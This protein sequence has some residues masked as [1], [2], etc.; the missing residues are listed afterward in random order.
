MRGGGPGPQLQVVA[1]S[2]WV[3]KLIIIN[4]GIWFFLQV[5]LEGLILGQGTLTSFFGFTPRLVIEYFFIWQPFSYMFLHSENVFHILFNMISLWF[6]GSE[7]EY[8]WGSRA[9]LKYYFICGVGA[10]LIYIL[11]VVIYGLIQGQEPVVYGIPVIGASGAV[12][13][14]LLAYGILFGDRLIYFFGVF[15]MQ[16]KVFVMLIGGVE[17]LTLMSAGLGGSRVANL[18]HIGGLLTGFLYLVVWTRWQQGRRRGG[19]GTKGRRNLRL[20]VNNTNKPK[21]DDSDGPK[22]WN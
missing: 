13:G 21:S 14:I 18:A 6:F 5:L 3:K 7:L 12:F 9:F 17:V 10:A 4:V 15:P 16:A 2:P 11:G 20:V 8:R 22:Y 19:K 1:I